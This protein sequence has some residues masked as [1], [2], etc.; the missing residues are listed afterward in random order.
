MT[1]LEKI[2]HRISEDAEEHA[3]ATLE[4]AGKECKAVAE[5]YAARADR[6]R[7]ESA[8]RTLRECEEMVSR[9]RSAAAMTRRNILLE[10]KAQVLDEAF[11]AARAEIC[12]TDYGKY[13]ELLIALL[14][15]ALLEQVKNEKESL[16][17]GDE[18]T[19]VEYYEIALNQ[20]DLARFGKN[21][22]EG[23]GRVVERRIGAERM[24]KLRL[25]ETPAPI[26]GG[27]IL[28]YGSVEVNCSLTTLLAGM[29]QELEERVLA[30][31]FG[32]S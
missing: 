13:R 30:V 6:I 14:S 20:A 3:R 27:L 26:D 2:L 11:E 24:A 8:Q 29:R 28:R 7:E 1:G 5:E 16:A 21:I 22:L 17:C 9:T 31:L 23:A 12:D 18:I 4:A 15:S 32:G 10:A 19:P 25:C